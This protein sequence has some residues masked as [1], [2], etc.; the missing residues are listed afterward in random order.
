MLYLID[1][2]IKE[3]LE[4]TPDKKFF[5]LL[6]FKDAE[7]YLHEMTLKEV[8]KEVSAW[9]A[10][11]EKTAANTKRKF[12]QYLKWLAK[13]GVSVNFSASD[14]ALPIKEIDEKIIY[15][16]ADIHRYYNQL[17]AALKNKNERKSEDT[18]LFSYYMTHAAGIL[19]FHGLSDK[20]ILNLDLSDV[21]PDGILGYDLPLTKEDIDVLLRYKYMTKCINGKNLQ[22][23]KYIRAASTKV[24][25]D[26]QYMSRPLIVLDVDEEYEFL[27]VILKNSYLNLYGKF[28]RAYRFEKTSEEKLLERGKIPQWFSDIFK[29]SQNWLTKRKKEYIAYREKRDRLCP[30]DSTLMTTQEKN[31]KKET[32]KGK[33]VA[34]KEYINQLNKEVEEL[35]NQLLDID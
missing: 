35:Q 13:K 31:L 2:Y 5:E 32:I 4:I 22:G 33:I 8:N 10:V 29:V 21:Q 11:N 1:D 25:P 12:G 17:E 26:A 6:R 9:A 19:A 30:V 20:E 14:I 24:E 27:K 28:D 7:K 16:T 15:S 18:N 23:T 34:I 3:C